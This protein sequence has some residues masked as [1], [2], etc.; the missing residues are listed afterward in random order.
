MTTS[1]PKATPREHAQVMLKSGAIV[2]ALVINRTRDG[3][4]T[5][6]YGGMFPF[7]TFGLSQ[8]EILQIE[9][10]NHE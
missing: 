9:E 4:L 8:Q 2:S 3:E 7:K 10:Q 5:V 1:M 6:M